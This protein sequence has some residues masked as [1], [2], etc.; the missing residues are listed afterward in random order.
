[1]HHIEALRPVVGIASQHVRHQVLERL[2]ELQIGG[3][4]KTGPGGLDVGVHDPEGIGVGK[5]RLT[6]QKVVK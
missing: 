1:M 5:G 3:V 6:G 2:L 4:G